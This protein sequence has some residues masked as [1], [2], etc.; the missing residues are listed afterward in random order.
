M[1]VDIACP[2]CGKT[3]QVALAQLGPGHAMNCPGCGTVIHFA[4]N[5]G[6]KVQQAIDQLKGASVKVNVKLRTRR[7][8]WKFWGA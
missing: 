2:K 4:G 7:P 1:N 5:D 6:A 3:L 8:W